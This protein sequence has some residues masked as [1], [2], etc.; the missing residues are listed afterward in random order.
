V[1]PTNTV[2]RLRIFYA[3]LTSGFDSTRLA[4]K[5]GWYYDH[6]ARSL[7]DGNHDRTNVTSGED[8]HSPNTR[9]L[10]WAA[11]NEWLWKPFKTQ[12]NTSSQL[13]GYL[14]ADRKVLKAI[15]KCSS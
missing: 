12:V 8:I 6:R 5:D 14:S 10:A 13:Q 1:P 9:Q 3:E 11:A 4:S 15:S 2:S 7:G